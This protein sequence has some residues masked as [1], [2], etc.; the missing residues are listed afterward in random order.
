MALFG[1]LFGG[2]KKSSIPSV[3]SI[4]P[5]EIYEASA[6]DLKDI[7]AP[8]AL[9]INPRSLTI[10]EK[11]SRTLFVISYPRF[12]SDNWFS[13]IINLDKIFD[14]SIFIRGYES[15]SALQL[16]SFGIDARRAPFQ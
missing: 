4:L 10:G 13:P 16:P 6:L 8:S 3:T 11:L 9:K 2:N 12:L 14:I 15:G 1:S 5:Q 7:I